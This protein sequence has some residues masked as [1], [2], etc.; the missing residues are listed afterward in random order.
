MAATAPNCPCL[1]FSYGGAYEDMD[2]EKELSDNSKTAKEDNIENPLV[3]SYLCFAK[4][5]HYMLHY[6]PCAMTSYSAIS[7]IRR[8]LQCNN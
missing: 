3:Y 2:R 6:G 4:S 7:A 5:C 1:P 8:A